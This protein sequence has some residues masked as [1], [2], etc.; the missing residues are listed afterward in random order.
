MNSRFRRVGALTAVL[1]LGL[2][3]AGTA[4]AGSPPHGKYECIDLAYWVNL[5][6]DTHYTVQTGGGGKWRYRPAS[7]KLVFKTGPMD[8]AYG[9]YGHDS[10]GVPRFTLY[11]VKDH[12]AY[13]DCIRI[14]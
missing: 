12:S 6:T 10:T 8:F 9:K 7:K 13:G 4:I 2:T 3:F 14:Q 5:K 11:D 1:A